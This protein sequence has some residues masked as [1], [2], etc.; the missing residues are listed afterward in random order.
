MDRDTHRGSCVH[1]RL[2]NPVHRQSL[3]DHVDL[4]DRVCN[5][6][7]ASRVDLLDALQAS[8]A[9]SVQ[10]LRVRDHRPCPK[11]RVPRVRRS[12][13]LNVHATAL[14]SLSHLA[15]SLIE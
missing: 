6:L 8:A 14:L 1:L 4:D 13:D 3:G 9:A 2:A 11:S 10:P 15:S 5:S 12:D 7:A